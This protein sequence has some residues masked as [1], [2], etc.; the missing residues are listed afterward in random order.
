MTLGSRIRRLREE[1]GLTQVEMAR[2]LSIRHSTVS[3]WETGK[4]T[5]DYATLRRLA[6][7]FG[8]PLSHLLDED[9]PLGGAARAGAPP[10]ADMP[11]NVWPVLDWRPVAVYGR[12]PAG[13]PQ[14]P[15]DGIEG[16]EWYPSESVRGGEF[17]LLR[18]SGDSMDGGARP[19]RAGDRVLI[20]R[21]PAVEDGEIAVVW[22]KEHDEAC[23]K[24]VFHQGKTIV[25][26]SDNPSYPPLVLPSREVSIIGK[27]VEVKWRV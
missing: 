8:V 13:R 3:Q 9:Q 25:L 14:P 20:R 24:R 22:W 26:V 12:I 10:P 15:M 21:Q 7:F 4:R 27:V 17:F 16:W 23:L 19:I 1:K 6:E 11:P 5:P 18:V 2:L